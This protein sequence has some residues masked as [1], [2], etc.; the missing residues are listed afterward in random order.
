LRFST[1][2]KLSWKQSPTLERRL[3]QDYIARAHA[4]RL[5]N[6]GAKP[7][8]TS[9]IQGDPKLLAPTSFNSLLMGAASGFGTPF[10]VANAGLLDYA[11][12]F[13]MPAVLR[14]IAAHSDPGSSQFSG[15]PGDWLAAELG[16][17]PWRW[18]SAQE[19]GFFVLKPS[20]AATETGAGFSV[21]RTMWANGYLANT[22]QMFIVHDGCNLLRPNAFMAPPFALSYSDPNYGQTDDQGNVQNGESLMFYANGLGLMARNKD[23]N[24]TPV[25]FYQAVKS[26]GR[27]GAGWRGYFL[28]DAAN[29]SLDE[30]AADPRTGG[31]ER[32]TRTLQRKRTYFWSMIGDFTL[33]LRY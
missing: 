16:G 21:Y 24:D 1:K 31:D 3:I 26:S 7:F 4:F 5:G 15:I 23:F 32:R 20:F 27:F 28:A 18:E 17:R 12:W 8:R 33:K 13:K 9:A 19:N 29:G 2:P 11:R 14:G 10:A 6:D 22:G 30:R 25:G